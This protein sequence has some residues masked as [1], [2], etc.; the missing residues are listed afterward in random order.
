MVFRIAVVGGNG[1]VGSAVCKALVAA[2]ARVS[3]GVQPAIEVT[4]ISPSGRAWR[5][6]GGHLPE[7]TASPAIRWEQGDVLSLPSPGQKWNSTPANAR[8]KEI[9]AQV[10]AVVHTVGILLEADYKPRTLASSASS[11]PF[12]GGPSDILSG[13]ARGWFGSSQA[14]TDSKF[15]Y[16]QMNTQAG[17]PSLPTFPFLGRTESTH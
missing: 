1:F 12:G 11:R 17:T 10:D 2:S 3:T 14:V 4:S 5:N 15:S 13:L 8:V 6:P 7:W 9:F 16:A